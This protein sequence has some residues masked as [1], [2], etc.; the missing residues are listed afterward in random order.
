MFDYRKMYT[1]TCIILLPMIITAKNLEKTVK[2]PP[3]IN[4]LHCTTH[5]CVKDNL[6]FGRYL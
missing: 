3:N 6:E 4:Y 1:L 2:H 5:D